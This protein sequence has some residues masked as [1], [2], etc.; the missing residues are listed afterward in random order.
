MRQTAMKQTMLLVAGIVVLAGCAAQDG[1]PGAS[2]SCAAVLEYDGH[3]YVGHGELV[4]DPETTGRVEDGRLPGCD[5]GNGASPDRTAKVEELADVPQS[6]AVLVDGQ[7]YVRTDRPFPEEARQWFRR[8]RCDRTGAFQVHGQWLAV[9][10]TRKVRFDGDL[11]PPYRLSMHVTEGPQEYVGT[12]IEVRATTAT[13][14]R[15]APEDVK[16]S[17]WRGGT[18]TAQVSCAQG[19]FV[20]AALTARGSRPARDPA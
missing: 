6:R 9:H 15:L 8:Q 2:A 3:R 14:P 17:L 11:R 10:T 19:D 12:T 7:L 16:A 20:A 18:V 1:S 13:R 4:R 5:D